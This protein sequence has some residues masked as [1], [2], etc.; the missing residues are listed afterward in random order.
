MFSS[1]IGTGNIASVTTNLLIVLWKCACAHRLQMMTRDPSHKSTLLLWSRAGTKI[2]FYQ[3]FFQEYD[4]SLKALLNVTKS[5]S[6]F[7][8]FS[9]K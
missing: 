9:H 7:C 1:C 4:L 2:K 6:I 5:M 3:R 8:L